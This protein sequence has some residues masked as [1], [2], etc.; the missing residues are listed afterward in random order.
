[1]GKV[2]FLFGVHNHQPV[3]N[4]EHVFQQAYKT[5]YLPFLSMLAQF[6]KIKCSIHTSGPLY[7]WMKDNGKEYLTILNELVKNG[8]VEVIS[9][10]YY[11]PILPL[12]NDKDKVGQVRL[13]NDFIE[14]KFNLKPGG[15]WLAE[16]V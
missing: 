3:G 13:M 1:M 15:F 5:C 12:I 7:D 2:Y 14:K 10:G 16:R 9:G 4:F 8:Q 11:E 6:P